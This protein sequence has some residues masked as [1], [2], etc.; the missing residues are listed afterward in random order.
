MDLGG[1]A[2]FSN[3]LWNGLQDGTGLY[4]PF[5]SISMDE[6]CMN[7]FHTPRKGKGSENGEWVVG[8]GVVE[9]AFLLVVLMA[10][11]EICEEKQ[12]SIAA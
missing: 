11:W 3:G 6:A 1:S 7:D 9:S 8:F 2:A 5:R 12:T 10:S 4:F